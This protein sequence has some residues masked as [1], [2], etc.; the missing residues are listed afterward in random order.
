MKKNLSGFSRVRTFL[1]KVSLLEGGKREKL[2]SS[3][4]EAAEGNSRKNRQNPKST[5][6]RHKIRDCCRE[7]TKT[8]G[9]DAGGAEEVPLYDRKEKKRRREINVGRPK[10]K[11]SNS[12]KGGITVVGKPVRR[13]TRE[14]RLRSDRMRSSR[15]V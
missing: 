11:S 14:I 4:E 9:N 1:V 5:G 3:L 12:S 10:K 6:R 2:Y 13:A 7:E 8:G 15:R